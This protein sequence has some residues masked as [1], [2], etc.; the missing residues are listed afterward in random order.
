MSHRVLTFQICARVQRGHV[1]VTNLFITFNSVMEFDGISS[2]TKKSFAR[3]E[4][5]NNVEF[6]DK[7]FH[8]RIIVFHLI[9]FTFPHLVN[10]IPQVS[11]N[12]F[13]PRF[14]A[15]IIHGFIEVNGVF[16]TSVWEKSETPVKKTSLKLVYGTSLLII[17]IYEEVLSSMHQGSF[18][19]VSHV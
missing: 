3:V 8:L 5:C 16:L 2:T 14:F 17:P 10:A 19:F 13:I 9:P 4:G 1:V 6:I 18:T 11:Q 7:L 15:D 12:D